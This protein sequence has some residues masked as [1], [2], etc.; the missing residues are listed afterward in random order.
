MVTSS[1]VSHLNPAL[2]VIP[3][4][5]SALPRSTFG[6]VAQ[7]ASDSAPEKHDRRRSLWPA[8][9]LGTPTASSDSLCCSQSPRKAPE[10]SMRRTSSRPSRTSRRSRYFIRSSVHS[11]SPPR[12]ALSRLYSLF[13]RRRACRSTHP[14]IWR[15]TSTRSGRFAPMTSTTGTKEPVLSVDLWQQL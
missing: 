14:G 11:S 4:P 12:V 6:G 9:P 10:P 5:H 7:E 15:T 1:R 13:P 8:S 2:L 3:S